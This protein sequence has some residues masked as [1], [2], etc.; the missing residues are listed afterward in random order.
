MTWH[1]IFVPAL[2]DYVEPN[3]PQSKHE[4]YTIPQVVPLR[5]AQVPWQY[6]MILSLVISQFNYMHMVH[7]TIESEA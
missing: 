7:V 4:Q 2:M 5:L 3:K 6:D 1:M